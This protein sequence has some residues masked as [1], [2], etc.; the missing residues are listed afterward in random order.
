MELSFQALSSQLSPYAQ[1]RVFVDFVLVVRLCSQLAP[2]MT[3]LCPNSARMDGDWKG[4]MGYPVLTKL[5][6]KLSLVRLRSYKLAPTL[7][8]MDGEGGI[9]LSSS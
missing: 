7:A 9:K 2:T 1:C 8:R 5:R 3:L 6:G 4:C